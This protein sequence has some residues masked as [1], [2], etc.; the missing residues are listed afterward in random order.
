MI[1]TLAQFASMLILAWGASC[2]F[3][4]TY[5]KDSVRHRLPDHL[6]LLLVSLMHDIT[7]VAA[8]LAILHLTSRL[9]C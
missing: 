8:V 5:D 6:H 3:P 4:G 9:C 7:G 2:I 1:M